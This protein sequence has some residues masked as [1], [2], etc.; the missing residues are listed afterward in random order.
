[1]WLRERRA[2][3]VECFI[4]T[5]NYVSVQG[6][7]CKKFK[8]KRNDL[9]LSCV[10]ICK[11]VK[12]FQK[13]GAATSVRVVGR[14]RSVW[15]V[16]NCEKLRAVVEV[17]SHTSLCQH[18]SS[19]HVLFSIAHPMLK[20]DLRYHPCKLQIVRELKKTDFTVAIT[21]RYGI[22]FSNVVYFELNGCVNKQNR[23]YWS[24]DNSNW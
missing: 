10:T 24:A 7:F 20:H 15:T 22:F 11:C 23:R 12:K 4:K 14:K 16:Q 9:V 17:A 6:A 3:V 21:K 19:L 8:L 2:F 5:E 18:A 1:M 13:T